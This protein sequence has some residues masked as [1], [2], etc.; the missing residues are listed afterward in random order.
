[1]VGRRRLHDLERRISREPNSRQEPS[2]QLLVR[3]LKIFRRRPKHDH[4][5]GIPAELG[6]AMP[7]ANQNYAAPPRCRGAASGMKPRCTSPTLPVRVFP[8]SW[9]WSYER[10]NSQTERSGG[11]DGVAIYSAAVPKSGARMAAAQRSAT[12]RVLQE[13][14]TKLDHLLSLVRTVSHGSALRQVIFLKS[15]RRRRGLPAQRS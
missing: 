2:P 11:R 12:S 13:L 15:P 3:T 14:S 10:T 8:D 1:V 4:A 6:S 9:Q 5:L 7:I